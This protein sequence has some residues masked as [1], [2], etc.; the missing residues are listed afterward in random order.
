MKITMGK[1]TLNAIA[2]LALWLASWGLSGVHLGAWSLAVALA[3]AAAKAILVVLFF[4]EVAA[5]K[6]TIRAVVATSIVLV[7]V[8]LV[9]TMADAIKSRD[10]APQV[11]WGATG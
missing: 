2:L 8:M 1:T 9:F 6:T 3:I 4:M 11:P 7:G 5:E 10:G